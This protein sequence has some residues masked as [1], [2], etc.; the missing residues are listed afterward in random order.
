[1]SYE[2]D[3]VIVAYSRHFGEVEEGYSFRIAGTNYTLPV[4]ESEWLQGLDRVRTYAGIAKV[5]GLGAAVAGL[6][7]A[8][9]QFMQGAGMGGVAVALFLGGGVVRA[10]ASV[11]AIRLALAPFRRRVMVEVRDRRGWRR[12]G[13][14]RGFRESSIPVLFPIAFVGMLVLAVWVVRDHHRRLD[15]LDHGA[16]AQARVIFSGE[17]TG[18]GSHCQVDFRFD[19]DER[20]YPGSTTQ[21]TI[22]DAYPTGSMVP[23]RYDPSDPA[24]VMAQGDLTWNAL[25]AVPIMLLPLL[26]LTL[27]LGLAPSMLGYAPVRKRARRSPPS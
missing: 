26:I 23:V 16:T 17:T 14:V 22:R 15:L 3:P 21:C 13:F 25:V 6:V 1:M 19:L 11:I 10:V 5:I 20:S 24:G 8:L 2:D 7:V 4:S 18:R 27:L 9:W 12:R